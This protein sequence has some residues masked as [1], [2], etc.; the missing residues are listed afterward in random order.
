MTRSRNKKKSKNKQS[1]EVANETVENDSVE[2]EPTLPDSELVVTNSSPMLLAATTPTNLSVIVGY[3]GPL[4]LENRTDMDGNLFCQFPYCNEKVFIYD[5]YLKVNLCDV[6][7]DISETQL[8]KAITPNSE[9]KS[10][11]RVITHF[12]T[13]RSTPTEILTKTNEISK[14]MEL[15]CNRKR[16][17]KSI[18]STSMIESDDVKDNDEMCQTTISSVTKSSSDDAKTKRYV[19]SLQS[20]LN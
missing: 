10:S 12:F 17:V 11:A 1:S 13:K 9:Y 5:P 19:G 7:K 15:D 6:H 4:G 2:N 3:I 16:K 14:D 20:N 8:K 18:V